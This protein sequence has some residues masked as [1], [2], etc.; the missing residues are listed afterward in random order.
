MTARTST[1]ARG[2]RAVEPSPRPALDRY[3]TV[4]DVAEMLSCSAD[5]VYGL[6]SDGVLGYVDISRLG[7]KI[8]RP[9]LRIPHSEVDAYLRQQARRGTKSLREAS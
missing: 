4:K 9:K 2:P 8:R 6:M 5:H 3:L 1:K 7:E